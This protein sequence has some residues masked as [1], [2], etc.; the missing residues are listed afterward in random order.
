MKRKPSQQE[1]AEKLR[2]SIR[3][4]DLSGASEIL[5]EVP[6]EGLSESVRA[7]S[8]QAPKDV[9]APLAGATERAAGEWRCLELASMPSEAF[10]QESEAAGDFLSAVRGAGERFDELRASAGLCH[11]ANARPQDVL[12]MRVTARAADPHDVLWVTLLTTERACRVVHLVARG[13]DEEPGVLAAAVEHWQRASVVVTHDSKVG[14]LDKLRARL[15]AAGV[16]GPWTQPPHLDLRSEAK[17]AWRG[18]LRSVS[19]RSLQQAVLGWQPTAAGKDIGAQHTAM[20]ETGDVGAIEAG[21]RRSGREILAMAG[22]TS[23]L[24]TGRSLLD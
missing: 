10:G 9:Y 24:L 17:S 23:A 15:D 19:L 20:L 18:E 21:L 13:P 22:I 8:P 5:G 14:D 4:G 11:V 3:R 7:S 6:P 16:E 12:L 2:Q 1:L